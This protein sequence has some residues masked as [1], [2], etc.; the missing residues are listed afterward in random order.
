VRQSNRKPHAL[1]FV[2]CK[3]C[4]TTKMI[5]H[6]P[7]LFRPVLDSGLMKA[8]VSGPTARGLLGGWG[9]DNGCTMLADVPRNSLMASIIFW[10]WANKRNG[11]MCCTYIHCQNKKDYSSSRTLHCHIFANS[12]MSNY[13]LMRTSPCWIHPRFSLLRV[14]SCLQLGLH[15]RFGLSRPP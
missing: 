10:M 12:F 5:F 8:L 6:P 2:D 14:T 4:T 15:V 3:I 7:H 13:I 11:F 9:T 1:L